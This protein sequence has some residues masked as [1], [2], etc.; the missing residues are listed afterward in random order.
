MSLRRWSVHLSASL[1]PLSIR[2]KSGYPWWVV[3]CVCVGAFM[4]ALDASITNVALPVL[5]RVFDV[6]MHVVEWVNLVYLLTLAGLLLPLAR[7]ADMTGR[8]WMYT[9]GFTV[10]ILGSALCGLAPSL[11]ILLIARVIQAIGAAMLQANSVA[12]VTA[13]APSHQ[14]GRAIGIQASAQGIGLSVGPVIGGAL[15]TYLGWKSI[16]WINVPVGILGTLLGVLLLPPDPPHETR[17]RFDFLGG[18]LLAP[19]LIALIYAL[20]MGQRLGWGSPVMVG[21]YAVFVLAGAGFVMAERTSDHPLLDLG[22]LRNPSVLNGFVTGTLAFTVMYAVLLLTPFYLDNVQAMSSV[23]SGLY[24][25]LVPVG[26]T[27]LTPVSGIMADKLGSRLPTLLGMAAAGLGALCL[28]LVSVHPRP[29]VV[30]LGLWLV[31]MGIGLFTPANNASVMS[32]SPPDRLGVAG[33]LLNMAR[34]IGMS[35]G[36]AV[37]GMCYQLLLSVQGVHSEKTAPAAAMVRAFHGAFLICAAMAAAA[38]VLS[39]VRRDATKAAG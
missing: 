36:V 38:W 35:L 27:L 25:T 17:Q 28:S 9:L 18:M 16:F 6:R 15:L 4:A 24:L 10:F 37:G 7:L 1:P 11:T 31:G 26:M 30:L 22:L 8:R 23:Q 5:R 13:A 21:S 20:N 19:S 12:I 29:V 34:S 14:R 39:A 32:Q 3:G 2:E 33:G